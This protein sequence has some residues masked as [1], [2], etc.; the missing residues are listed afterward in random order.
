[1][2]KLTVRS[3]LSNKVRFFMTTIVVVLG[4]TFVVA[5]FVL[6]DSIRDEFSDI[7]QEV[8]AGQDVIV[9]G[10]TAFGDFTDDQGVNVPESLLDTVRAVPGVDVAEGWVFVP[11]QPIDGSGV[12]V[13]DDFGP[14]R[15]AHFWTEDEQLSNLF[16][17][18]G[19]RPV[20]PNEF[21]IDPTAFAEND[22]EFGGTYT[23]TT[24][25]GNHDFELVGTIQFGFPDDAT[26]GLVRTVFDED[27]AQ[28]VLGFEDSYQLINVRADEGL[29]PEA[30]LVTMQAA[31]PE[32]FEVV[33]AEQAAGEFSDAFEAIIGPIQ[34]V[35]L[36]FAFI[37][38]FVSTFII[39]NTFNIT[40]G[41]RVRELGLL[42]ALGATGRQVQRSV[43]LESLIIGIV[44]TVIGI[45]LGILGAAGL[46]TA[47]SA[48]GADLA[49]ETLPL[50]LRTVIWAVLL[51]VGF[52]VAAS[53]IPAFKA[54]SIPPIAALREG[55]SLSSQSNRARSIFGSILAAVGL[56]ATGIGLFGSLGTTGT[57][58]SLGVGA[59]VIFLAVG[60]LGP[61]FAGR[62]VS[63][64]SAPLPK[65]FGT[66]GALARENARRSPRRTAAT[67]IALTI[68][69]ALVTTVAVVASSLRT[70]VNNT[71]EETLAADFVVSG[72]QFGVPTPVA[73]ALNMIDSV[74]AAVPERFE[75]VRFNGDVTDV[76]ATDM[77]N[78]EH[79]VELGEITGSLTDGDPASRVAIS[80]DY[81]D[82]KSLG[83]GDLVPIEFRDGST[84]ELSIVAIYS[85]DTWYSNRFV[86]LALY[87]E[88]GLN[89]FDGNILLAS[90][91]DT[92]QTLADVELA[93]SEF[94]QLEVQSRAD[95]IAQLQSFVDIILALATVF[96]A[97]ALFIAL[98]GIVN[99]LTLSVFERTRE[100]GLLRAVGMTRRQTRK[101]I[102]W[103]AV[104]IAVF[105]ALVGLV[106]GFIFG[107][108]IVQAVPDDFIGTLTI[109][110]IWLVSF[111]VTAVVFGLI[112]AYFP[113]R[114]AS[115]MNVL[116]AISYE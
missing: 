40:L 55:L 47:A 76:E 53:L 4:V 60:V 102:R 20:G 37:V 107:F 72:G 43:I 61:L 5:S 58:S 111:L 113:A 73:S 93:L 62:A 99:T 8:T 51:G 22:F 25:T 36:V 65:L 28:Q 100:I 17:I 89:Q 108:A 67:A 81:A 86:D 7:G 57:L 10:V 18:D 42:R 31:L 101:M 19:R 9:R 13:G 92:D 90:T 1:M 49:S 87:D 82:D 105:G 77:A 71:L 91:G 114:R 98:V 63:A 45:G 44:A 69:L 74:S 50:R 75:T 59:A 30:L 15:F 52:T 112:A 83:L 97:L 94:P 70:S 3:I 56:I 54:A 80:A 39:N 12:D 103:E 95:L 104:T 48:L 110:W 68:G 24:P 32:G 11:A 2:L 14:P 16:L 27:T 41:Q 85:K 29:D 84:R 6:A 38:L 109:P 21:A 79:V 116:E 88:L 23:V 34:T 46:R 78:S 66:P 35:L 96:L 26:A 64:I 33:S 106:L 115:R